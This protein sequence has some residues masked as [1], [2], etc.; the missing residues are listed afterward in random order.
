MTGLGALL[1]ASELPG[2]AALVAR[3]EAVE[4]A[5]FGEVEPDSICRIASTTQPITAAVLLLVDEGR[6]A[7]DDPIARWLPE[8]TSPNVVRTP[9]SPAEDLVPATRPITVDGRYGWVGGTGTTAHA[10]WRTGAVAVLHTQV[11]MPGPT[12][13]SIM[14]R[15]W[16][17]AFGESG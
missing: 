16:K 1:E 6:V 7:P 5:G 8:L 12:P 11:Q 9:E 4:V 13:T 3:G 17:H 2:A 14:R 15:F 10:R